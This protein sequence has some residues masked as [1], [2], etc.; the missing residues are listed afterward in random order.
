MS[1]QM[2]P[3]DLIKQARKKAKLTQ[4][5]LGRLVD[6]TGVSIMRYEKGE[7]FP[8]YITTCR[9]AS[10]LNIKIGDLMSETT[11]EWYD[12]GYDTGYDIGCAEALDHAERTAS[13]ID[14]FWN[15]KN[16]P[17]LDV[18]RRIINSLY[19]YSFS[20]TEMELIAA[21]SKLNDDCQEKVAG[22][23]ID[24]A[25]IPDYQ[26]TATQESGESAPPAQE[27]KDTTPLP[28]VP[29]SPPEGE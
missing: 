3:G 7:R 17:H 28:N 24:L 21:F 15:E 9:L 1:E 25:K 26:R 4:E 13:I 18:E 12:V 8:D 27:G 14:E 22:Y 16:L 20:K 23:A 6:V 29:K 11:K 5:E 2:T 10:A 19:G